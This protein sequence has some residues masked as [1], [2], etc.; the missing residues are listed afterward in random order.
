[1]DVQITQSHTS[2]NNNN[3]IT[4]AII[5]W[6]FLFINKNSKYVSPKIVS[7]GGPRIVRIQ[8]VRFHYSTIKIL[9]PKGLDLIV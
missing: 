3:I 4:E 2:P 1:M 7:T 6:P 9:V 5:S 8:T